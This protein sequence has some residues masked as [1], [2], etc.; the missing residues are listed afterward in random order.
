MRNK[1]KMLLLLGC[2][3]STAAS[4][5]GLA[6]AD[7]T[8]PAAREGAA[9]HEGFRGEGHG[10]FRRHG[11][12]KMVK[13]LH[14]TDQQ[15]VQ[16]QVMFKSNR[17]TMKPLLVNMITAK[18]QLR[19]MVAS[20]SADQSA[21]QTQAAAVATAETNL[22]LQKAQNTRKFLALLTPDQLNTYKGLQ[23]KREAKFQKFLL[24]MES[25]GGA[26]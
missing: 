6:L 19:T 15:K 4:G 22:A 13:A 16:A 23:A 9:V 12:R 24:K 7:E 20:G 2:L 10:H 1:V 3:V 8:A 21:I 25:D 18:H 17:E 11:F 26:D 14:L 5:S